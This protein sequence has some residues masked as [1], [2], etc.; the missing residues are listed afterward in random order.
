MLH[1]VLDERERL[2]KNVIP[3]NMIQK[4]VDYTIA[5]VIKCQHVPF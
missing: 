1:L 4:I 2:V 5:E 3:G